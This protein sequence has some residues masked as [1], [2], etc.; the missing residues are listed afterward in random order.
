MSKTYWIK[1]K[2]TSKIEETEWTEMSGIEF[3]KFIN[4]PESEGRYFIDYD[5][6]KI[7][8][9]KEE[10]VKWRKEMNHRYYL[11]EQKRKYITISFDESGFEN[12][13]INN[14]IIE[15]PNTVIEESIEKPLMHEKVNEALLELSNDDMQLIKLIYFHNKNRTE[16]ALL[17]NISQQAVS[18]KVARILRKLKKII[19]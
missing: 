2:P 6:M 8:A 1:N 9:N 15:I 13:C 16:I 19:E 17:S 18:K 10:Y 5:D 3:Y 12:D 11:N 4:S 7:E 14:G